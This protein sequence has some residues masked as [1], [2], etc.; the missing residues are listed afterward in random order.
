MCLGAERVKKAKVQTLKADFES[1]KMK[2]GEPLDDFYLKLNGLVANIRALGESVEES[3]VVKK[4][5]RAVPAKFLQIASTIEQF[6]DLDTISVEEAIGSLKAHEER[7]K[8]ECRNPKR[9]K[10]HLLEVNMSQTTDD[11]PTLLMTKCGQGELLLNERNIRPNLLANGENNKE[12]SNIWYLDNGASNHM[13]GQKFKFSKLDEKVTGKARFGD[14]STVDIKGKGTVTF[15]CKNGGVK[16]FHE[17]RF[18]GCG[19]SA[20]DTST[21]KL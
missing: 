4:L 17:R 5:L 11:E 14:G 12:V 9:E 19:T 7:L 6:G 21:F 18:P 15:K 2:N 1:L 20:W 8:A 10:S 13:T 16:K 3:Y